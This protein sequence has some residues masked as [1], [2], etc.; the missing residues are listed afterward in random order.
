MR[1]VITRP[2]PDAEH[3]A[4]R[5]ETLGHDALTAPVMDMRWHRVNP[6][7]P[8]RLSGLIIT[9]RNALRGLEKNHDLAPYADLPL[10]AVGRKSAEA[11][12]NRGF[13]Q[14][15][16]AAGRAPDLLPLIT[17]HFTAPPHAPLYHPGGRKLAFDLAP[18]LQREGIGLTRQIVYETVALDTLPP[19]L[20]SSLETATVDGVLLLS[21][22]TARLFGALVTKQG[23]AHHF[24]TVSS[25]CLSPNVAAAAHD[26]PWRKTLIA[27]R[28]DLDSL[29]D[30]ID[31]PD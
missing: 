25:L 15:F 6:P 3:L 29:L 11:A 22:R 2:R 19:A 20:V 18:G 13:S 8:A 30:L 1:L 4:R 12:K 17:R 21:P 10:F 5:I 9:S 23:L 31:R 14:V 28:P 27:P 24:S 16:E 7:D 26:L